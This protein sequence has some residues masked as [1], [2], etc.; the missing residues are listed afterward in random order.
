MRVAQIYSV[1]GGV[2]RRIPRGKLTATPNL[3][4]LYMCGDRDSSISSEP[5]PI[6]DVYTF[7]NAKRPFADVVVTLKELEQ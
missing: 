2:F 7:T 4:T 1:P 5:I 6:D 3:E